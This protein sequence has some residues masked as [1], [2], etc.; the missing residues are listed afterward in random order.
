[1]TSEEMHALLSKPNHAIIGINRAVGAPQLT[2][3]W[4]A[5]DGTNFFF[6]TTTDRAKYLNL[7]R[8]PSISL[9]VDDVESHKYVVAYGKAE[10]IEQNF[11]ELVRSVIARY[12]PADR[13][14]QMVQA[15]S[16][17]PKR[18]IVVFHPEKVL[19]N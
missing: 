2:T 7:K 8:D 19:T 4:Y 10:I 1:M 18:V 12:A 5:W 9:V 15:V 11:A 14:E 17:D 3:V 6:S 16:N 13:V